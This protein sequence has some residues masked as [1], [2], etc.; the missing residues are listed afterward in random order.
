[1][2]GRHDKAQTASKARLFS[3]RDFLDLGAVF[4]DSA[5]KNVEIGIARNLEPRVVHPRHIGLAQNDAVAVKFVP[6]A[7]VD[8]AIC[9]AADLVQPNAIDVMLERRIQISHPDLNVAGPQ[10]TL[11]R[12]GK[13]PVSSRYS[14]KRRPSVNVNRRLPLAHVLRNV[15]SPARADDRGARA[16]CSLAAGE[17]ELKIA[18]SSAEPAT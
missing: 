11:K 14:G 18:L 7:Q 10:H 2:A 1:M 8:A 17:S 6:G 3:C 9:L 15:A 4:L 5:G 16:V 12:H 13:P